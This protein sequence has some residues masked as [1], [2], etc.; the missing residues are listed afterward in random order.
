[1]KKL[2]FLILFISLLPNN[3]AHSQSGWIKVYACNYLG[4]GI[5]F[6]NQNT[7]YLINERNLYKSTNGGMNWINLLT[8]SDTYNGSNGFYFNENNY[9]LT[10]SSNN[11]VYGWIGIILRLCFI[12]KA[13][14]SKT[15]VQP[16][17]IRAN[18]HSA[19]RNGAFF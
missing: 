3:Y 11:H 15:S 19:S 18:I 14:Y 12:K 2:I 10:G 5:N 17:K 7:G 8:L 16:A 13:Q 6:F 9:V 1:M 4:V